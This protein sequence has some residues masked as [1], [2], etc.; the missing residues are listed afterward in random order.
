MT[1]A[2]VARLAAALIGCGLLSGCDLLPPSQPQ[3]FAVSGTA[4]APA[5]Q[6][7]RSHDPKINDVQARGYCADGYDKLAET[8]IPSDGG[9]LTEWR[10]R[11]TPYEVSFF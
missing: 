9:D 2:S 11:C 7:F 6:V 8:T 3:E 5:D 1:S 10:V 4:P